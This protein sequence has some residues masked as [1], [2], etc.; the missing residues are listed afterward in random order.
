MTVDA[1][2]FIF[3]IRIV[4]PCLAVA[5]KAPNRSVEKLLRSLLH[6]RFIKKKDLSAFH[7]CNKKDAKYL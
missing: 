4:R 1:Y 7:A 5:A 6:I 2:I 3:K